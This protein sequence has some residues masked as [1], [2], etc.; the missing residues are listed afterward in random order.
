MKNATA[1]AQQVL[2]A[3]IDKFPSECSKC[4][5]RLSIII[6]RESAKVLRANVTPPNW[7]VVQ[8]S[9]NS[10]FKNKEY[11][12]AINFY[13]IALTHDS[14]NDKFN[15]LL[16]SNRAAAHLSLGTVLVSLELTPPGRRIQ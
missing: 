7:S 1:N 4:R 9:G 11:R 15:A 2:Q 8:Q 13:T 14:D 6:K 12:E 5:S 10:A 3:L 16:F